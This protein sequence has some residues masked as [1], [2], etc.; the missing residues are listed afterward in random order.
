M[1]DLEQTIEELEAE[2]LAEL[3]EASEK[4]LGKAA[5]LGLGSDNAGDSV[6]NAKDPKPGVAGVDKAEKVEG[7][8]AKDGGAAVVDPDAKSSPTD[9]ATK[10]AKQI[11]GDAQQ[12]SA[13]KSDTPQKLAA[14]DE[15]DH[16]GEELK[17][18]KKMTKAQALEQIGKMKKA[19][20]EEMLATH[21]SKL[22]EA[23]NAATE[24]ELKKLEDQ[25]AEIEEKIKS[26]NVKEAVDA[27]VEGED[28]SEE[29]KDKAA[30]I[31]EAAVKSK[32][33]SE[34][35]R[36]EEDTKSEKDAEMESFK[37]EVT[38]KVDTYLNYVVEEWTKENE[39]AIERGLK[40]EIAED[41]ISGLKQLFEDHYIDVPDEKYDVLEAQ[42]EKISELEKK[43]NESIQKSVDLTSSNSTL[44]REQVISEVSEDLA[45]TEIEKFK[46]LTQDVDFG[47]EDSFRVKLNTLKESYFPKSHTH[48]DK[49]ID[50]EDGSTAQ[51]V[52]TTDSMKT[53]MSAISRNQKASA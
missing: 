53:Y 32:I 26:I 2:V 50:D 9:V 18:N 28:L 17:E 15:I 49:A 40:G 19:D 13:G 27:L 12:K 44:V 8:K 20:I 34:I 5:D 31:F 36:I 3:E 6:S 43:L 11:S 25:K 14:G 24:E 30:T 1:S 45:D 52:D 33:R 29:F 46:S 7:E 39:L 16:D 47:D 35:V 37:E 23:D 38:E 10:S 4:P 48:S 51:D 22:A 21:S 41:F 42:S